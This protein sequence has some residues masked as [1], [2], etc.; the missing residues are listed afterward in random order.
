MNTSIADYARA[1]HAGS[2]ASGAGQK[3]RGRILHGRTAQ[4]FRTL[5]DKPGR[6]T[7][8]MTLGPDGLEAL[9][10][11][12]HLEMLTKVVCY[13]DTYIRRLVVDQ[14]EMFKLVVFSV[15][16]DD[17]P[18]AT[19]DN[20]VQVV[21]HDFPQLSGKLF[22][23]LPGLKS[24]TFS[25]LQEQAGFNFADA[26]QE[27]HP[28]FMTGERLA[29]CAGSPGEVRAFLYHIQHLRELFSGDGYTYTQAGE[30]VVKE[31]MAPNQPLS[32]LGEHLL[33]DLT[34]DLPDSQ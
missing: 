30:R 16:T 13:T 11:R 1:F 4:D 31:Y 29:V 19:W 22:A 28:S 33:I 5:T 26:D 2:C 17:A 27:G 34:I 12:D 9:L 10:G 6:R 3:L 7:R 20:V 32:R 23:A 15:G 18:E 14:E 24:M 25:E 8:V 21:T